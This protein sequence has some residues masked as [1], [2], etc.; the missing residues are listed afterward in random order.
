MVDVA[1]QLRNSKVI[2]ELHVKED[3]FTDVE[4]FT[5]FIGTYNV[6]GQRP[7]RHL[8]EWLAGVESLVS[9]EMSDLTSTVSVDPE[10]PDLY[11]IGFQEVDLSKEAFVFNESI[12]ERDWTELVQG[13]E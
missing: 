1:R 11:A 13:E 2:K 5:L 6:G 8:K 10:P 7:N 3:L 9:V 4:T 12:R